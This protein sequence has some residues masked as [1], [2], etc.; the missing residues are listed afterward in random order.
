MRPSTAVANPSTPWIISR[1]QDL[2]WIQGS[3]LA[4]C[5]LLLVFMATPELDAQSFEAV[6]PAVLVLLL[7]GILFDGTHV[8]AT[9]ARTYCAADAQSRAGLPGPGAWCLLAVGPAFALADY[10]LCEPAPSLVG[11]AGL[12]FG[13]F[14]VSAYL[15]AYYHL[16]RQH[17][18]LL[19]LYRRKSNDHAS[20]ADAIFLWVG[21]LYPF[22]RFSLSDAYASGGLPHVLPAAWFE[23]ARTCLD[24]GFLLFLS[25]AAL[26]AVRHCASSR[27][28]LAPK[29][30]LLLIVV[31]FHMLVF[32]LLSNLLTIT[33]TLT[34]FHNLQYHRMVWLYERGKKR[35]PMGNVYRYLVI[36]LAFGVFWY[37]PR[38]L[39]VAMVET[40][41]IRNMLLGLGWGI[42][43]HHYFVDAR[44]WRVRRSPAIAE[45]LDQG[46]TS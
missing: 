35:V 16:I 28:K 7:W 1:A 26:L 20:R 13:Y 34:I 38:T 4:G 22:A 15:W 10:A 12:L 36:G 40:D 8:F 33:A 17:Y 41:L 3:V 37:A 42:A 14:L 25:A 23:T 30:L 29:H 6:Q 44:I 24:T 21:C 5:A 27:F 46:A 11:H 31:G 2:V 32:S 39:G 43:F 19:A 9:Y 18:G 45:A